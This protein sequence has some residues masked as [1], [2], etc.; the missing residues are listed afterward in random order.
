MEYGF[1][2]SQPLGCYAHYDLIVDVNHTLIKIQVK[3][4]FK[5]KRGFQCASSRTIRN[6]SRYETIKYSAHDFDFAA[7]YFKEKKEVFIVP[8]DVFTFSKGFYI[9]KK[10]YALYKDA[11]HLLEEFAAS[12]VDWCQPPAFNP[13]AE[14]FNSFWGRFGVE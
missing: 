4:V 6:R 13:A 8:F 12:K 3:S 9:S 7:L 1:V 2:V 14:R 11:W 5:H 10:G